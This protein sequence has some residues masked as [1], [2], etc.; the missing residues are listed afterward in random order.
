MNMC[1]DLAKVPCRLSVEEVYI[2]RCEAD[3]EYAGMHCHFGA[4]A[5]HML[6]R[7]V[8]FADAVLR[9][10]HALLHRLVPA[11]HAGCRRRRGQW[12]RR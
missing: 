4:M 6:S 9:V 5:A 7:V 10:G 3:R 12:L 2:K 11:L 8:A 1:S